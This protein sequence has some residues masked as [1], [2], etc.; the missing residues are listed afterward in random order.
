MNTIQLPT[1]LAGALARIRLIRDHF[2]TNDAYDWYGDQ[3]ST[4]FYEVSE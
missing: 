2:N 1:R 4:N 3:L